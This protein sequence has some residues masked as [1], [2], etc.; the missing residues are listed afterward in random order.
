MRSQPPP[1][2]RDDDDPPFRPPH[3][4]NPVQRCPYLEQI[5]RDRTG[6][7]LLTRYKADCHV[8]HRTHHFTGRHPVPPCISD[9]TTCSFYQRKWAEESH[10]ID[11]Y[12]D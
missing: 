5:L 12:R 9:P 3:H 1:P 2:W 6:L 4:A 8:D 10:L 7:G 11:R